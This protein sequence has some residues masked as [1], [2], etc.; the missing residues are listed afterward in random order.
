M[1]ED[2][3]MAAC[4]IVTGLH[5]MAL[6]ALWLWLMGIMPDRAFTWRINMVSMEYLEW[7]ECLVR[8]SGGG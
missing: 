5:P 3:L 8:M 1:E 7:A 2:P 6:E 4:G